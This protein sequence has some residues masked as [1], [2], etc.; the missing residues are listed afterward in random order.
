M[1]IEVE[2]EG[3]SATKSLAEKFVALLLEGKSVE[4]MVTEVKQFTSSEK[5]I[6][7]ADDPSS[8]EFNGG[9]DCVQ[10]S[11]DSNTVDQL[12]NVEVQLEEM[13]GSIKYCN[14]YN[15]EEN[16]TTQECVKMLEDDSDQPVDVHECNDQIDDCYE[17]VLGDEVECECITENYVMEDESLIKEDIIDEPIEISDDE[18][19]TSS[20]ENELLH[21]HHS[22]QLSLHDN[23]KEIFQDDNSEVRNICN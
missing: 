16:F 22:S 12:C 1:E 23:S 10:N 13:E 3:Q 14:K 21:S 11:G 9:S 7:V 8:N 20:Y 15:D 6:V 19:M 17:S 4:E 2:N 18:S 5:L